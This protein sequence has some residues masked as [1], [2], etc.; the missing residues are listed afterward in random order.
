MGARADPGARMPRA[1]RGDRRR[2]RGR[3]RSLHARVPLR[4][5]RRV[6]ARGGG[7]GAASNLLFSRERSPPPSGDISGRGAPRVRARQ[8]CRGAGARRRARLRSAERRRARGSSADPR[9]DRLDG[10]DRGSPEEQRGVGV[11]RAA[12][13]PSAASLEKGRPGRAT[14]REPISPRPRRVGSGR[15]AWRVHRASCAWR[16]FRVA[17]AP[18]FDARGAAARRGARRSAGC[19]R[20]GAGRRRGPR[21]PHPWRGGGRE[22]ARDPAA[23]RVPALPFFA[24]RPRRPAAGCSR[25]ETGSASG[26]RSARSTRLRPKSS[27]PFSTAPSGTGSSA[28]KML[29]SI[30][31]A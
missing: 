23:G 7:P 28:P 3:R 26:T 30:S 27:T 17:R 29:S 20:P 1:R 22:R 21:P 9:R 19:A 13:P 25:E 8:V 16:S 15:S 6:G 10:R 4:G 12:R 31:K 24:L 11:P 2:S 14:D 18:S 5:S